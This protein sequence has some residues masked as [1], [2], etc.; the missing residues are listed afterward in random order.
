MSRLAWIVTA[1]LV[2]VACSVETVDSTTTEVA[3]SSSEATTTV[4][5]PTT[6]TAVA[7][8]V[9]IE[10]FGDGIPLGSFERAL[11]A[12]V[13]YVLPGLNLDLEVVPPAPGWSILG[14]RDGTAVLFAWSGPSG[15]RPET[16]DVLVFDL[17]VDVD[18]AWQRFEDRLDVTFDAFGETWD[19]TNNGTMS[20]GGR[21]VEWREIRMPS[22]GLPTTAAGDPRVLSL[23]SVGRAVLWK[24][25]TARVAVVDAEG[26]TFTI[27]AY[28]TRC[29][30]D[31][32]IAWDSRVGHVDAE[33]NELGDWLLELEAFLDSI[34]FT[35]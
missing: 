2:V 25:T 17:G 34:E 31:V 13:R 1:W 12:D 16:L 27:V 21:E 29:A 8:V 10:P 24:D 6:T 33:E 22:E 7:E 30:C 26:L 3:P 4:V 19:W 35:G 18:A 23:T 28:E 11:Q 32:Q 14:F 15:F 5:E 9:V 20:V